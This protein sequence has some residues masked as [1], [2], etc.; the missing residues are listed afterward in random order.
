[1]REGEFI[2]WMLGEGYG[3]RT[4]NNTIKYIRFIERKGLNV[5]AVGGVEDVLLFFAKLREQGI[6]TTTINYYIKPLNRYFKFRRLDF[7]LKYYRRPSS[8]FIW[9]PT[10]EEVKMILSI[11][12]SRYDIDLRNRA[13]LNLLFATGIRLGELISLNWADLDEQDSILKVRTLKRGGERY[14][15]IPP[16]VLALLLEYKKVRIRSDPNA[17]FTTPSGRISEPYTRKI[18][19]DAGIKAGVRLE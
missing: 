2:R 18:F 7:K 10:D 3:N 17:M 13:M 15:P 19:K 5:D 12:W 14:L 1:M 8:D 6:K 4:I 9:I 11:R 16:K